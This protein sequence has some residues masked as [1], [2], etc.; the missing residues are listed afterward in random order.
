MQSNTSKPSGEPDLGNVNDGHND[1]QF[2]FLLVEHDLNCLT[3]E[4]QIW[5]DCTCKKNNAAE[6]SKEDWLKGFEKTR[7]E[8]RVAK[9]AAAKTMR[10]AKL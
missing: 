3:V 6:L 9:R 5:D 1:N 4:S 10:K 8:R 7:K 2:V